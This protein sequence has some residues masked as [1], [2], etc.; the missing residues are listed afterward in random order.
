MSF[1]RIPDWCW[2]ALST[3]AGLAASHCVDDVLVVDRQATI[4][5][6][7]PLW[8]VLAACC[9]MDRSKCKKSF[10]GTDPSHTRSSVRYVTKTTRS[11]NVYDNTTGKLW[12]RLGYSCT[13]MFGRFGGATLCGSFRCQREKNKV[14][15]GHQLTTALHWLT[16]LEQ[17][18][19]R[20]IPTHLTKTSQDRFVQRWRRF[21]SHDWCGF[22]EIGHSCGTWGS[23]TTPRSLG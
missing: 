15:L 4:L 21:W 12:R 23:S 19:P 11:P 10:A 22:V 9:R 6:G 13:Q 5:S 14:G 20:I 8:R 17:P 1:A 18:P 2:H 7:R 16:V 3:S